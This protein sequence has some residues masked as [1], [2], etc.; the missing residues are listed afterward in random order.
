MSFDLVFDCYRRDSDIVMPYGP[1]AAEQYRKRLLLK[2]PKSEEELNSIVNKKTKGVA[3]IVS[4]CHSSSGRE[5]YVNELKKF[6]QVDVYGSC[7]TFKCIDCC[8]LFSFNTFNFAS[9]FLLDYL[10]K[11]KC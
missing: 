5:Q 10:L 4:N 1:Y 6:I 8:E 7:G 3:W 2:M 11:M 9:H